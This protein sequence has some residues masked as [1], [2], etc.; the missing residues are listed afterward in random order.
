MSSNTQEAK[1]VLMLRSLLERRETYIVPLN[2]YNQDEGL[3]HYYKLKFF[4][5][6]NKEEYQQ[7]VDIL[8]KEIFDHLK[9]MWP[10]IDEY[11]KWVKKVPSQIWPYCTSQYQEFYG[12]RYVY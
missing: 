6:P 1:E 12:N 2:R 4:A 3:R 10:N 11:P 7:K 5:H 8:E 9:E